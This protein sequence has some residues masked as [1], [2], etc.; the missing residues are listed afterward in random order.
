MSAKIKV[1]ILGATG[2]VGQRFVQLLENHPWFEISA[3]A[4]SERSAG[5]AYTEAVNWKLDTPLPERV[6]KL[7]VLEAKPGFEAAIAFSGLDSKV[8]GPIEEEFA[9]AGYAVISN[10][11]NH[12]MDEDVPL[13]LPEINADHIG[14]IEIQKNKRGYKKGFIVTNSNCS[15]MALCLGLA[16]IDQA[17]GIEKVMVTTLQ[18]I[19]GAGYPGVPALDIVGNV[20][21]YIGEEEEKMERET[22]KILGKFKN[23]KIEKHPMILSATTTRVP[24]ID[25]HTESVNVKLQKRVSLD[26]V[27][28]A[29]RN[30]SSVPQKLKLP[31]APEHPVVLK[32][33]IDR[34]Q[35]RLDVNIQKGMATIVG[36]VRPCSIFD[37]KFVILG[38]NTIRGAAGAAILNAEL[39]K[40]QGFLS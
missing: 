5:K 34:P 36:R 39:L 38:H 18:A 32:E 37:W 35:P 24:V 4:A 3:L 31:S 2:A 7:P 12:R 26:E 8:A 29:F 21:P 23:G 28:S 17:F 16:P 40:S 33:E 19:S 13:L 10:S 6:R 9:Q 14:L 20:I 25:G 30:Y 11:K 22:Q 1:A 27:K 15:A